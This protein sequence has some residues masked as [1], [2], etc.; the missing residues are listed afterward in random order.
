MRLEDGLSAPRASVRVLKRA[1]L[2]GR[3]TTGIELKAG[4]TVADAVAARTPNLTDEERRMLRVVSYER[5]AAHVLA[6]EAWSRIRLKP[7]AFLV[8]TDPPAGGSFRQILQIVV[9]IAALALAG[10]LGPLV[11]GALGIGATAGGALAA[12][13]LAAV[14]KQPMAAH[15]PPADLDPE[16]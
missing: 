15:P 13:G 5:G 16:L 2:D 6:P 1:L 9:S 11:G 4:V 7:G 12:A 14:N 3:E 10:P 8:I